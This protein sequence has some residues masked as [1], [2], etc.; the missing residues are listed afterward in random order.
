MSI[1]MLQRI[2]YNTWY[3]LLLRWLASYGLANAN[4][5]VSDDNLQR[6]LKALQD[7]HCYMGVVL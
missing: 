6:I 5:R 4:M 2:D 3:P 1:H 7:M